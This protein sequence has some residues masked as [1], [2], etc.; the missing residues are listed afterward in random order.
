MVL[1]VLITRDYSG[2]KIS[3]AKKAKKKPIRYKITDT[4]N[5]KAPMRR[6]R[7][8]ALASSGSIGQGS[9][10]DRHLKYQAITSITPAIPKSHS[11]RSVI[12]IRPGK[13]LTSPAITLPIPSVT[14]A[15][16]NAQHK[17]V[18][19]LIKSDRVGAKAC[20]LKREAI[21]FLKHRR[22]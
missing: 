19:L 13:V 20:L 9:F 18:P 22:A 14:S 21:G 17:S 2:K 4:Q 11:L 12:Q 7:V 15:A 5:V 10:R 6:I 1:N 3:A 8:Q 16:G